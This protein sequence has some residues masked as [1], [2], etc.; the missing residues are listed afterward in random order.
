VQ[1]AAIFGCT[2]FLIG[3]CVQPPAPA[4]STTAAKGKA[5]VADAPDAVAAVETVSFGRGFSIDLPTKRVESA[6]KNGWIGP[7]DPPTWS[8]S[9][10]PV[11]EA[12]LPV[13]TAAKAETLAN[14]KLLSGVAVDSTKTQVGDR[15]FTMETPEAAGAFDVLR[16]LPLGDYVL[17][18]RCHATAGQG[19][20]M[21]AACRSVR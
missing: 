3:G 10:F 15:D 16:I 19:A 5:A 18:L 14:T 2:L 21:R 6:R 12:E 1:R 13:D 20:A 4:D 7:G 11:P 17:A 8:V 9:Y